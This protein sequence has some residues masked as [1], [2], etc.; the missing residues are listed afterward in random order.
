MATAS[1]NPADARRLTA[2]NR[3]TE[4]VAISRLSG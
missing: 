2:N 3:V 4:L 1:D